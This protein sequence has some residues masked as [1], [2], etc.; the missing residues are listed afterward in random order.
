[1]RIRFLETA[2]IELDEIIRYYNYEAPGLGDAF[3]SEVLIR[4]IELRNF[5]KLGI[6]AQRE[7]EGV[8]LGAFR[9]VSFIKYLK[10]RYLL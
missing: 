7:R 3:L 10:V 9:M 8:K 5:L 6:R 2:E 1:M 4:L